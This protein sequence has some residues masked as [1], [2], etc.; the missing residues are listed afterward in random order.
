MQGLQEANALLKSNCDQLK[1]ENMQLKQK[2][3]RM[4]L[5]IEGLKDGNG[6]EQQDNAE[7]LENETYYKFNADILGRIDFLSKVHQ[8][9]SLGQQIKDYSTD[10]EVGLKRRPTFDVLDHKLPMTNQVS[11]DL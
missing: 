6:V 10:E 5:E 9:P 8:W 3:L 2:I 1:T 7:P 11:E 4:T